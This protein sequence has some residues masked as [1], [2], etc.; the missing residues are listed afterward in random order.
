M[1]TKNAPLPTIPHP[2]LSAH[3]V[4]LPFPMPPIPM[5]I[6]PIII[7]PGSGCQQPQNSFT[8]R[9]GQ[10]C[11]LPG[12][13]HPQGEESLQQNFIQ[14]VPSTPPVNLQPSLAPSILQP[15]PLS[16]PQQ[17][18][19]IHKNFIEM[20]LLQLTGVYSQLARTVEEGKRNLNTTGNTG[21]ERDM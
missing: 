11:Y 9:V 16:G 8:S 12:K 3:A 14:P 4:M 18:Q 15:N 20:P 5:H 6:L 13:G 1:V 17:M 21:G 7:L 2:L 10:K 19:A